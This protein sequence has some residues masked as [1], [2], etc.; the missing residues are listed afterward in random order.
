[1]VAVRPEHRAGHYLGGHLELVRVLGVGASGSVHLGLDIYDD[2][3]YA[4]KAL[5]KVG[6][7]GLPL[8]DIQKNFQACEISLHSRAQCHP[9][10]VSLREIL[11]DPDC[12]YIVMEFCPEGDLFASITE[13]HSYVGNDVLAKRVFLQLL[14]AVQFCHNIG[15]YH[16]DLK[17][18]NILVCNQGQNVKLADFGLATTNEFTTDFGCG[19]A[20]YMSPECYKAYGASC[21]QSAPNDVWSLGVILVNL[22]CGRNPWKRAELC[23]DT[24]SAYLHDPCFLQSILPL[25]IELDAILHRVFEPNPNKRITLTKLR[26]AIIHCPCFTIQDLGLQNV[27]VKEQVICDGSTDVFGETFTYVSLE[28]PRTPISTPQKPLLLDFNRVPNFPNSHH[29]PTPLSPTPSACRPKPVGHPKFPRQYHAVQREYHNMSLPHSSGGSSERSFSRRF[30]YNLTPEDSLYLHI[31]TSIPTAP[32]PSSFPSWTT[33][34]VLLQP[35]G[36]LSRSISLRHPR[37]VSV[38]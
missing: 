14:D 22:T 10:I 32:I 29:T 17:P 28:A 38:F 4:V 23:D 6:P 35:S 30:G 13:K 11:D 26:K 20:F 27:I 19:S 34:H 21:Y 24:Y 31:P 12:V 8:N 25:S 2:T 36:R 9:N 1:M 33:G 5:S 18:E 37:A 16:R 15:I 3:S 7:T